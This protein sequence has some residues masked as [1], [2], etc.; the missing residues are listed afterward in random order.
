[1]KKRLLCLVLCLVLLL[2]AVLAGCKKQS[3]IEDKFQQI[4]NLKYRK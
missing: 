1:M 4:N 2:P 3:N